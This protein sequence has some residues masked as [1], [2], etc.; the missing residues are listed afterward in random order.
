[1][2]DTTRGNTIPLKPEGQFEEKG[3]VTRW[4]ARP[5]APLTNPVLLGIS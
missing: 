1:M 5:S 3:F 4:T 2:I